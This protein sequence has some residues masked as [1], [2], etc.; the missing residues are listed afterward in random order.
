MLFQVRLLT[1]V[2]QGS[3]T[4]IEHLLSRKL[5]NVNSA[6]NNQRTAIAVAAGEGK[7]EVARF[8]ISQGA[9]VNKT[10]VEGNTP[11][12]YA[13]QGIRTIP[14]SIPIGVPA[15]PPVRGSADRTS[16]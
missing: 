3:Q 10:D 5:I 9:E 6:D 16:E 7:V 14:K 8:L 15:V 12:Y 2:Q 11:L 1:A 13:L 4:E